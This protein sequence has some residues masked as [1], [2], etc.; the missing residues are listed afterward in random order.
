MRDAD[1]GK[2]LEHADE[3]SKEHANEQA[4]EHANEDSTTGCCEWVPR[5]H[6]CLF[7]RASNRYR[8]QRRCRERS[9][10]PADLAAR[11]HSS[12]AQ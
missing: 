6:F 2:K 1:R 3:H 7:A 9:Q 12:S 8:V 4:K 10:T 5:R 11:T